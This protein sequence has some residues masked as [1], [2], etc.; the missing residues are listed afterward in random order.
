MTLSRIPKL[1]A[2]ITL[3]ATLIESAYLTGTILGGR[4]SRDLIKG[5]LFG[6]AEYR[7][8]KY[9]YTN[10]EAPL[11]Q[12]IA[13]ANLQWRITRKFSFAL[14]YEGE[15]QNKNIYHRIYTNLIHRL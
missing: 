7:I 8:V 5:K 12:S 9:K 10:I 11:K 4:I 3:S 13:G 15:F 14:H 2:S 6:E 1:Q